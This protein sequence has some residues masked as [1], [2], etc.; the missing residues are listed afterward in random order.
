LRFSVRSLASLERADWS[1]FSVRS[2]ASLERADWSTFSVRSLASLER[3]DWSNLIRPGDVFGTRVEVGVTLPC[4][5]EG[6]DSTIRCLVATIA[7]GRG[8]VKDDVSQIVVD[9]LHAA[10]FSVVRSVTVNRE[11][12][13]IQQLVSNVANGNEADGIILIGGVGLGPRDYT[14]EAVDEMADRRIEGFGEAYRRLLRDELDVGVNSV[15]ARAT[16]AVC[17]KCVV[18]AFPR[19]PI[20]LRRATQALVVPL[21]AETVRIAVGPHRS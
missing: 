8:S 15:I 4:M 17:N 13:F 3:A 16:A 1:T 10:K 12:A 7:L 11:K 21:L 9:E 18:M 20:P 6:H 14:C 5:S 2:L 19:Q